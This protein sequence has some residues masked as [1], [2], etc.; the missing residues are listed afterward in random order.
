[1]GPSPLDVLQKHPLGV[2]SHSFGITKL[3]LS[4]LNWTF[5]K[6]NNG[7]PISVNMP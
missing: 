3:R 2:A 7:Y 4:R 5:L 1:M 6:N